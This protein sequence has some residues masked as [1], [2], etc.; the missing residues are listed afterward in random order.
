MSD[1]F[2]SK[3]DD[4]IMCEKLQQLFFDIRNGCVG[5][6][7]L[8]CIYYANKKNT[9]PNYKPLL[10]MVPRLLNPEEDCRRPAG[11]STINTKL[12][13]LASNNA[14]INSRYKTATEREGVEAL[15]EKESKYGGG[16]RITDTGKEFLKLQ[17]EELKRLVN[18][19]EDLSN[20]S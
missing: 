12:Q 18:A 8:A 5:A 19:L 16:F 11:I 1:N 3:F 7:V 13:E 14:I 2:S 6:G 10:L 9:F 20:K 17:I 15:I 4:P